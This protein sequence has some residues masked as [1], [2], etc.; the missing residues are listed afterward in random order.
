MQ[1]EKEGTFWKIW[2]I[3]HHKTIS[4]NVMQSLDENYLTYEPLLQQSPMATIG[5]ALDHANPN[6]IALFSPIVCLERVKD[7][8]KTAQ[9]LVHHDTEST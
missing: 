9:H 4:T 2:R 3:A 8:P 7:N 6:T 5:T 1:W